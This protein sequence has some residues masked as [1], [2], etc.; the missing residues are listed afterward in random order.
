MCRTCSANC[1]SRHDTSSRAGPRS[2]DSCR[3]AGAAAHHTSLQSSRMR[4]PP[5][6]TAERS[7]R[8]SS[9]ELQLPRRASDLCLCSR[10]SRISRV[11]SLCSSVG[12]SCTSTPR[13]TRGEEWPAA[14]RWRDC[15]VVQRIPAAFTM[16]SA[17]KAGSRHG[18]G[19]GP[20]CPI[21]RSARRS[22][23]A[24][25]RVLSRSGTGRPSAHVPRD[26]LRAP[27][28]LYAMRGAS[29]SSSSCVEPCA[30]NCHSSRQC[31]ITSASE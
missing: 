14:R 10:T 15:G 19:H 5:T 24:I 12:R 1:N 28:D 9:P 23:V 27:S 22:S 25:R 17:A 6:S 21:R 31:F 30:A 16:S 26:E 20:W 11:S 3:T 18:G 8:G 4:L 29:C 2:T 13:T 7:P